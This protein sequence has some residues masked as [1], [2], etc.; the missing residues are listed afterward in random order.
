MDTDPLATLEVCINY[1]DDVVD[2][3]RQLTWLPILGPSCTVIQQMLCAEDDDRRGFTLWVH[4]LA[5]MTGLTPVK[6]GA[7]MDRLVRFKVAAWITDN[8]IIMRRY[9]WLPLSDRY[10]HGHLSRRPERTQR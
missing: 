8:A 2:V 6:V 9:L 7:T 5:D 3:A 10:E 4:D 1:A